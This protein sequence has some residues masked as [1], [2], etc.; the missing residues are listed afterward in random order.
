MK[1]LFLVVG[2]CIAASVVAPI[3]SASA[4]KLK[5]SCAVSGLATF[6]GGNLEEKTQT[7]GYTFSGKANCVD[8]GGTHEGTAEVKNGTFE[9]S[10][11]GAGKS[12]AEGEGTLNVGEGVVPFKLEFTTNGGTVSLEIENAKEEEGAKGTANFFASKKQPASKCTEA[13]GVHELEF[14]ASASGEIGE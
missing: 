8:A 5:G 14:V 9:G 3:A 7:L 2:L 11:L 1:R 13:G 12:I 10:C 4:A 6:S